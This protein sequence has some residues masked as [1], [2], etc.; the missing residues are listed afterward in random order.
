MLGLIVVPVANN[1]AVCK[2]WERLNDKHYDQTAYL[3]VIAGCME[4]V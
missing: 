2:M 4:Q 1:I 3:A